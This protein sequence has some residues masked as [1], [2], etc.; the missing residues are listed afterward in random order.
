MGSDDKKSGNEVLLGHQ[1]LFQIIVDAGNNKLNTFPGW[2]QP[3]RQLKA[4]SLQVKPEMSISHLQY[5]NLSSTLTYLQLDGVHNMKAKAVYTFLSSLRKLENLVLAGLSTEV[6]QNHPINIHDNIKHV[7]KPKT[8]KVIYAIAEAS[9]S[10]PAL[11]LIEL[12]DQYLDGHAM[13]EMAHKVVT[14]V[15]SN[16]A[17]F[18]EV[19]W[20]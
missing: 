19:Q 5:S 15:T 6:E 13:E 7:L 1:E 12:V 4:L 14:L 16:R 9:K 10:L 3:F 18:P 20:Y 2:C 11:K 8:R 17:H